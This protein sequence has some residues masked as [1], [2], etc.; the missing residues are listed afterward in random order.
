MNLVNQ[1]FQGTCWGPVLWNLFYED[2]NAAIDNAG[3]TEVKFADD[4]NAF[5]EFDA[6]VRDDT[7]HKAM[8]KCQANLH[9]WG[10][11]NQVA[12][13]ASKEGKRILSR[14]R[15]S[16]DAFLLLG[17]SFD[18]ALIM[19]DAISG[20]VKRC[21]WKL[22]TL[23]RSQRHFEACALVNLYK[24]RM[25]G[26]IEYRTAAIYHASDSLLQTLDAI[27]RRF[28]EHVGASEIEALFRFNLAP[29][30]SR[31]D[32]A[33]QGLIHRTVLGKGSQ[34]FQ[35]FFRLQE[36]EPLAGRHRL[37][38]VEYTQGDYTDFV[39]PHS[40][41]AQYITHSGLGLTTVYNLLPAEVVEASGSVSEFQAK[42]QEILRSQASRGAD[43]W[44][45]TFS[46]RWSIAHHPL[47]SLI[48]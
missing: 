12:F 10:T 28:L 35:Q 6:G 48:S 41:P 25:L 4:L 11:A 3:S 24:S 33:M 16:G 46:P 31:R 13:D 38:L 19:D 2:S 7:I 34:H 32:S 39:Y 18:C 14:R 27:Q 1:F 17:V 37:Q 15:P 42:L 43:S 29:L 40:Q 45:S 47:R 8:D 9:R 36:G 26:F 5:K 44:S 23:L 22:R 30:A 21:R 20:L